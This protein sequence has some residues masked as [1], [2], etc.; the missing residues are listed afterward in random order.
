M[1]VKG[2]VNDI[3]YFFGDRCMKINNEFLN[4][5]NYVENLFSD[6]VTNET[7]G[8]DLFAEAVKIVQGENA[9][10]MDIGDL[11]NK[12][13]ALGD[14]EKAKQL[15]LASG[16]EDSEEMVTVYERIQIQLMTYCEDYNGTGM[17][18]D[19]AKMEQV[20]G[21]ASMA[22]AVSK[23]SNLEKF[24]DNTKEYMIKNDLEP[25]VDN[26][27][28]A[29]HSAGKKQVADIDNP[30]I[31]AAVK[32]KLIKDGYELNDENVKN[33]MWLVS[34]NIEVNV[35]NM[36][37]LS[38]L[39][40]IDSLKVGDEEA[41]TAIMRNI[42]YSI[43]AGKDAKSAY[44]T[45]RYF[46]VEDVNEVVDLV[47]NV[48]D[49]ELSYIKENNFTLNAANIKKA[50]EADLTGVSS[51]QAV[52]FKQ[53]IFEARIVMT[54]SS[55]FNLKRLGVE[56]NY[57]EISKMTEDI[58]NERN[59]LIDM[60]AKTEEFVGNEVSKQMIS[61]AI[62]MMNSF[63]S[64]PQ[65]IIGKVHTEE[66]SFTMT[67]VYTSGVE[68]KNQYEM[69]MT[70]YETLGTQV[71]R[72]LGDSIKK[73]FSNVDTLLDELDMEINSANERA[74]RILGYNSMEITPENVK[75]VKEIATELDYLMKN[76][77]PKTA[78]HLIKNGI[79]PLEDNIRDV[80]KMLEQINED[81]GKDVETMGKFLWNLEKNN[82]VTAE[83]KSDYIELYRILNMISKNDGNVIGRVINEGK[84][85]T[86]KN[87]YS[88]YKSKKHQDFDYSL[89][90]EYEISYVKKNITTFMERVS[91]VKP[92]ISDN[93]PADISIEKMIDMTAGEDIVKFLNSQTVSNIASYMEMSN[94]NSFYKKLKD[95]KEADNIVE[96]IKEEFLG[97]GD[98]SDIAEKY[99]QLEA[100][101]KEL[102]ENT[103]NSADLSYEKLQGSLLMANA[104]KVLNAQAKKNSYIVPMEIG[105]E[106]TNIHLTIKKNQESFKNVTVSMENEILGKLSAVFS[107][108]SSV[109][110]GRVVS[111]R[112]STVNMINENISVFTRTI[113]TLEINAGEI[114][115]FKGSM[116]VVNK[117][118]ES[119]DEGVALNT[120]YSVAKAF[121]GVIKVGA[122]G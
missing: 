47:Q 88:A 89:S 1:S 59:N 52:E 6:E 54:Q 61:N 63:S 36:N 24:N 71:R 66:I 55:V 56:I 33:A 18:I 101:G 30:S 35:D 102:L 96:T 26:V 77:T 7:A 2:F 45:D 28:M 120:Y 3:I 39:N 95:Y 122:Q 93:E 50:K 29:M 116:D 78:M 57:T 67:S 97:D 64:L 65:G 106:L 51:L 69:A 14:M 31:E 15:G 118:S 104:L 72:D 84:E 110:S 9:E 16:D 46:N 13:G 68:L 58:K 83:E 43:Y 121:V 5:N 21:S 38:E 60:L 19:K 82:Q 112:E 32:S 108:K 91:D 8:K 23:A 12:H 53:V 40:Q 42:S 11:Y 81:L 94:G 85:L 10:G 103:K 17:N 34:R 4:T 98:V 107:I 49:E 41:L 73:A 105:G 114:M 87:L 115:C 99:E 119:S 70:S 20:L 100:A 80:N 109:V 37:K 113:E 92:F 75:G 79:N 25:T 117:Y 111:D 44:I 86:L 76:M 74:V 90:D 22:E 27:Y 48:T 62:D